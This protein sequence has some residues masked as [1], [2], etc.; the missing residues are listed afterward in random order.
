MPQRPQAVSHIAPLAQDLKPDIGLNPVPV[1]YWVGRLMDLA[2]GPKR[3]LSDLLMPP[4]PRWYRG[5]GTVASPRMVTAAPVNKLSLM[6]AQCRVKPCSEPNSI[7]CV[8][9]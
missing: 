2:D 6:T 1:G 8:T 9:Q 4:I 3:P 7:G 5:E